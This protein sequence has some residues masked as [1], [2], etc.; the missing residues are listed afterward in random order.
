MHDWPWSD[1]EPVIPDRRDPQTTVTP[2]RR[3]MAPVEFETPLGEPMVQHA[4][5]RLAQKQ[6]TP[7]VTSDVAP[8]VPIPYE[9]VFEQLPSGAVVVDLA[10]R[11]VH[12]NRAGRELL[13]RA[14]TL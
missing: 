5:R 9:L 1:L 14:L 7:L 4:E 8:E 13:G 11:V 3:R 10:G 6:P 12:T 2:L